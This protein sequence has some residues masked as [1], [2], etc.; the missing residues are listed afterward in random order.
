MSYA[1]QILV[2]AVAVGAVKTESAIAEIA[3]AA[4][5]FI[6]GPSLGFCKL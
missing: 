4:R 5:S 6:S 2:A 1:I 3:I